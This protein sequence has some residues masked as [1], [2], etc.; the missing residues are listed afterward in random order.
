[1]GTSDSFCCGKEDHQIV[2]ASGWNCVGPET[3]PICELPSLL[4]EARHESKSGG[5]TCSGLVGP[6]QGTSDSCCCGAEH[7]QIVCLS[8]WT[9]SGSGD[10]LPTCTLPSLLA[11]AQSKSGG[12]TCSGLVGPLQGTSDSFCC[13]AEHHQIVCLSGWTCNG[14][15][16]TLPTCTLPSL[17]AEAQS[18]S[19]GITCSG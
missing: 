19:G 2:C 6:L 9:C 11:E 10:T 5:I 18:K 16:D 12:I 14:S 3:A 15:G 4:A 13:G 8:G 17:L 7:H 1:M